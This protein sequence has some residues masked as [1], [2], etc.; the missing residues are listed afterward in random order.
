MSAK[1]IKP[2]R[3]AKG[4]EVLLSFSQRIVKGVEI[5]LPFFQRL[6]QCVEIFISVCYTH[7]REYDKTMPFSQRPLQCV[8]V[9]LSFFQRIVK[10]VEI[11]LSFHSFSLC[12][13]CIHAFVP[14]LLLLRTETVLHREGYALT[15]SIAVARIGDIIAEG[16][17]KLVR[18][19]Y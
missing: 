12:G 18:I 14:T 1:N 2:Q 3:T 4:V 15:V 19:V 10:G 13:T 5:L 7:V 6:L 9:L 8:E 11:M 16:L 17:G